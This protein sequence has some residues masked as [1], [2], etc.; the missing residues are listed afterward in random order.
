MS[1]TDRVAEARRLREQGL[2]LWEIGSRM[3]C[4]SLKTVWDLLNDPDL[5][6]HRERRRKYRRKYGGKCERCG[7]P[8]DGSR[9]PAKASRHCRECAPIAATTWTREAVV[10][11]I[12]RFAERY[13]RQPSATD[14][15][16]ALARALGNP[17]RGE[18]F[19]EDGDYPNTSTVIQAFGSWSAAIAA[20]GFEPLK[21]G[22]PKTPVA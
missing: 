14:F 8:T 5:V 7:A 11:A 3:G 19:Y 17:A 18:R 10:A 13:G 4:I 6:K 1:R 15:N 9:G 12:Q 16:P 2:L 21:P 20:A 22:R